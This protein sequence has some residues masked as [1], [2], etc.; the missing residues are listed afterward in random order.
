MLAMVQALEGVALDHGNKQQ[1]GRVPMSRRD[2]EPGSLSK[3]K[4]KMAARM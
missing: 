1:Q 3:K 2:F 4:K